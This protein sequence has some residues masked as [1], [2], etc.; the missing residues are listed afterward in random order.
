MAIRVFLRLI[1]LAKILLIPYI[2]NYLYFL[3]EIIFIKIRLL[4]YPLYSFIKILFSSI[5][6]SL[7]YIYYNVFY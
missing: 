3:L 5:L 7:D 2:S 1:L 6:S 4:P